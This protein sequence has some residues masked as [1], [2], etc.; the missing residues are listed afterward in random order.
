MGNR[1]NGFGAC[2]AEVRNAC[3]VEM[4][5][6]V[7]GG[8]WKGIIISI[9][10]EKPVRFNELRRLIPGISQRML[11]LQ[12]RDL[13]GDGI[14]ERQIEDSVPMKVE[15]SLSEQGKRLSPIIDYMKEWG[16]AY[17]EENK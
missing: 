13:E 3:P 12:L 6:H 16:T 4:T 7:I 11:T 17:M 14:I 5:L 1:L 9:L 10:S 2:S 15:Y 8:K